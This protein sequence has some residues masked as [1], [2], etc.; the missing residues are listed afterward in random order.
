M[1][2]HTTNGKTIQILRIIAESTFATQVELAPTDKNTNKGQIIFIQNA[3]IKS[4][5]N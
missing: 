2:I 5:T 4:I 3:Q 1:T